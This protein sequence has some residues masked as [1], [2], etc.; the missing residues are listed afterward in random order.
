MLYVH[1]VSNTKLSLISLYDFDCKYLINRRTELVTN[2]KRNKVYKQSRLRLGFD[3]IPEKGR[4][5]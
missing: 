1:N 4:F 5:V 2:G 3:T